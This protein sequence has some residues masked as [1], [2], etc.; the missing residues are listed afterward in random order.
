VCGRKRACMLA[1]ARTSPAGGMRTWGGVASRRR[2]ASHPAVLV[3]AGRRGRRGCSRGKPGCE[4]EPDPRLDQYRQTIVLRATNWEAA[5][6]TRL[7][8]P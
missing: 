2:A 7:R 5:F 1:G 6:D 8:H 3:A 4:P